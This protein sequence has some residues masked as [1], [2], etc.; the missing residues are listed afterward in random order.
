[1]IFASSVPVVVFVPPL[2]L[3]IRA[4]P[5]CE[6]ERGAFEIEERRLL[7][8]EA[9][10]DL[11][12]IFHAPSTAKGALSARP[13]FRIPTRPRIGSPTRKTYASTKLRFECVIGFSP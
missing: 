13:L 8:G 4:L 12:S 7:Q 11:N 9:V 6:I 2:T 3:T 1:M 10:R 5:D